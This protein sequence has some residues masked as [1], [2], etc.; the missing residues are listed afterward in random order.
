[1]LN[2]PKKNYGG[3]CD[4]TV[5]Y[6]LYLNHIQDC[7]TVMRHENWKG[8]VDATNLEDITYFRGTLKDF[9][10]G[11]DS[12]FNR[13]TSILFPPI[14]FLSN[15]SVLSGMLVLYIVRIL[16]RKNGFS[17]CSAKTKNQFQTNG[18]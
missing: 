9:G 13:N 16:E 12:V 14:V 4:V 15:R 2:C 10:L 11:R 8:D 18:R 7:C 3:G 6:T 1:M 5:P 17:S